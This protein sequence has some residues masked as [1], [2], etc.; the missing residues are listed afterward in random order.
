VVLLHADLP[1]AQ[2]LDGVAGDGAARV[3]VVVPDHRDDGTPVL[4]VPVDGPFRFAYG[5]GSAARHIASARSAGLEVRVVRDEALG[6]D[7]DVE[8]DLRTL[9]A[10]RAPQ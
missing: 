4:A 6:F 2:H 8:D 3:A 10:L 9:D 5:P 1:F 7:V